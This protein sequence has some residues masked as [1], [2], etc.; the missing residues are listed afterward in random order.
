[1]LILPGILI[2]TIVMVAAVNTSEGRPPRDT[3]TLSFGLIGGVTAAVACIALLG[4]LLS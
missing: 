1:M 3:W 2:A 4:A